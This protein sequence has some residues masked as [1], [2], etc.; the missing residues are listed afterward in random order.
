MQLEMY[1]LSSA[2]MLKESKF[3]LSNEHKLAKDAYE[4]TDYVKLICAGH[5]WE[6]EN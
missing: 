4:C 1:I 3:N 5:A 6:T 2:L